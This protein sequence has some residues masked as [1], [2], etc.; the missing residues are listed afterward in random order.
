MKI[1]SQSTGSYEE[2]K[3]AQFQAM[4]EQLASMEARYKGVRGEL[5][6]KVRA[7]LMRLKPTRSPAE[8]A[9]RPEKTLSSIRPEKILPSCRA[10]GRGMKPNGTDGSLI[11]QNGHVRAAA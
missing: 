9:P 8:Q 1:M 2:G 11:C 4:M 6:T 10:C 7:E 3:E 5:L